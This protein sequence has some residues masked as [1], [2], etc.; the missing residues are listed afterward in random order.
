MLYNYLKIA[1]RNLWKNKG[2]AAINIVG[3]SIGLASFILITLYVI[4]ELSYDRYNEK[5]DRIF[6]INADI[7]FGGNDLVLAV[8]SDP[9]GATLKKDYPQV[10]EYVRF[11]DNGPM[12][13]KKGTQFISEREAVFADSTLFNVFTLPAIAGD[14]RTAL[15]DPNT[16]VIT[17]SAAKKYFSS[18]DVIGK[19]LETDNHK[20]YKITALI[21]DIPQ[22]SHF[23]FSCIF[24][25]KNV[26]YNF[27]NFLSNNFQT[28]ILLKKGVDYKVFE[29][30]FV[31]VID[32]YVLPQAKQFMQI[33]SMDDFEKAGNKMAY[34]LIPLTDI[35]LKSD[36][37]AELDVNGNIQYVYI[38]SAVALFILLLACINFMNLSTARSANR[39]KEVAIRK[40]LGSDKKSL[41]RQFLVESL[42]MS[43]LS[44]F[45]ALVIVSL[46]IPFFNDIS[47]KTLTI[48][49]LFGSKQLAVIIALPIAVGLLAGSYP[50]FFLSSFQPI[51]ILKGKINA[52]FKRSS[53][54][55]SLVVFQFDH[56]HHDRL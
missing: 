39:A 33:K 22:N 25:M 46:V 24:S 50:A 41:I 21:K 15:N 12:L 23:H 17:E 53:L 3:L 44:M 7:R 20:I 32:K 30:N 11:F 47:A 1:V 16:V 55:N 2:F 28:Y 29:K 26:D 51:S 18:Q 13:L 42:L 8:A 48:Q 56:R 19:T 35:H 43:F 34:S 6:R 5:A 27:G 31:Q 52:G 36:R 38:F 40:V 45:I 10:E 14:T 54:R 9:M 49:S 4:D 37:V